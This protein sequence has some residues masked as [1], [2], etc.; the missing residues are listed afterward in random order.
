[1]EV[2]YSLSKDSSNQVAWNEW[3]NATKKALQKQDS[4]KSIKKP[5]EIRLTELQAFNAMV[6]FLEK[7]YKETRSELIVDL[8]SAFTFLPD[9]KTTDPALWNDWENAKKAILKK[10]PGEKQLGEILGVSLTELQAFKVMVQFFRGYYELTFNSEAMIFLENLYLLSDDSSAS[11]TV[12]GRWRQCVDE[13]LKERP[14]I[15]EY[16]ILCRG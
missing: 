11:S 1:M 8:L 13:A 7:Y 2:I 3:N 5:A 10:H 14:G 4:E 6:K 15:R 9:G 16:L 12:R